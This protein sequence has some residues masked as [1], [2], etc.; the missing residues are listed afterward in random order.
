MEGIIHEVAEI[1]HIDLNKTKSTLDLLLNEYSVPFIARYRKEATGGLNEVQIRD[2]RDQYE[3]LF[4]LNERKNTILR[5]ITEQEKL[6]PELESK[7]KST[8]KRSELEDLYLPFKPK[9]RTRGQVAVEKGLEQISK[10]ILEQDSEINLISIF[11]KTVGTHP[12]LQT[13]ESVIQGIRD[14]IAE[15]IS[16]ISDIRS[17]LREWALDNSVIHSNVTEKFQDIKTKYNNYYDFSE[18]IHKITPHR[19][20]ALRRGEKEE[21]LKLRFEYDQ[22]YPIQFICDKLIKTEATDEVRNFLQECIEDTFKRLLSPH[23]ETEIRLEIKLFAE[24]E[25][26]RVFEKNLKHLLLLPPIH[27]R[28][29]I[30]IDPGFRTGSKVVVIDKTGK[31]LEHTTIY[32][33]FNEDMDYSKNKLA[34]EILLKF[35]NKYGASLV[36]IGNGTAGREVEDFIEKILANDKSLTIRTVIVN[37]AGAS[38]YSA[39]DVAREEFPNLDVTIRGA[40]SIARRLQDPL[41]E[42]VK[43]NPKSLGIGQYQHDVN[44]NKLKKQLSEV[45][46][47]CVN[48]VGVNL[49]TASAHLL[50]FVA[51]IGPHTAKTIVQYR[52]ENGEFKSRTELLQIPGFGPKTFEQSAGFLRVPGSENPLDNT[53]VHPESYDIVQQMSD[54]LSLSLSE[55]LGHKEN[56]SKI[57]A[58]KFTNDN[59]GLLTIKDVVRELHKP[60]RD[61]RE[62]GSKHA[63]NREIRKFENLEEGQTLMGT[64]TN[65]SNFGAFVD[66]GVHQDGL[67]HVSELA[68]TF[69]SDVTK[70]ISIG[71]TV[72]VKVIGIDKDRKRISLS[73][74]AC[75]N[76][77]ST[78]KDASKT[79]V[80][81]HGKNQFTQ[82]KSSTPTNVSQR[83]EKK[84]A[85]SG[86][87]TLNDLLSKYNSN[88][89]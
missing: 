41:S 19:I 8:K 27:K 54:A 40:I 57:H 4:L 50:S 67:I 18:S 48:Y 88:R 28:V 24:I 12:E 75:E 71:D 68:N 11:E 5:S 6:T 37:E 64:V 69:V 89:V 63:Y 35:I 78:H 23:L 16:E 34:S 36:A 1:T 77:T 25:A 45:V 52:N 38:V 74:K 65:V 31:L 26:I 80:H 21:I 61:P 49:N 29:V 85:P 83:R 43:I 46:E 58:E 62:D 7:I 76:N 14:Y 72:Q 32:P 15:F 82:K 9:K 87:V 55:L 17:T 39:S 44:Q 3:H 56:L 10:V 66:I 70:H 84:P 13:I 59:F 51:G 20:M 2:I 30:G 86:P 73:K 81:Q 79:T 60:G 47:S 22:S 42:L 53:A 33:A